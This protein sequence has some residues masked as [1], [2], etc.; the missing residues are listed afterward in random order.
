MG[1]Q[2]RPTHKGNFSPPLHSLAKV[3]FLD[4]RVPLLASVGVIKYWYVVFQIEV[5]MSRSSWVWYER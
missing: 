5:A 4:E 3:T 1:F 2:F